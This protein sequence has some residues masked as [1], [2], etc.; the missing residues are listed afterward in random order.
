MNSSMCNHKIFFPEWKI[1]SELLENVRKF[2]IYVLFSLKLKQK[3]L[4][5]KKRWVSAHGPD[6]AEVK[7]GSKHGWTEYTLILTHEGRYS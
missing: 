2:E 6:V 5:N 7:K 4:N 3:S 1:T